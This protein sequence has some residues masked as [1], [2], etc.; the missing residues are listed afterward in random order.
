MRKS[1]AALLVLLL[2]LSGSIMALG[3]D[4]TN[5]VT[6]NNDSIVN[7]G[8]SNTNTVTVHVDPDTAKASEWTVDKNIFGKFFE[9]NGKD[10]YPGIYAQ[11]LANGS[12]EEWYTKPRPNGT[13]P[14]WW[15]RSEILY[16]DTNT[17]SGIAYPWEPVK[18]STGSESEGA[19]NYENT[20]GGNNG[21]RDE[22]KIQRIEVTGEA[23]QGGMKQRI[24][25]PDERT[26]AYNV[27]FSVR[28]EGSLSGLDVRLEDPKGNVLAQQ[29][30]DITSEWQRHEL[31]L[32]LNEQSEQRFHGSPFGEYELVFLLEGEGHV[33][34]D[35]VMLMS[36]DAVMG[37]YNPTTIELLREH[38]VTSLR[39]GGNYASEYR[40]MDGIGP[41]Q[42]R[43]VDENLNWGGLEPNYMGTNEFLEF[44]RLANIEPLIN[45]GFSEDITP[46]EAAQW[47][48]YVNGDITTPM[49][50]LRAEHGYPK[51]WNVKLW[52][53]GNEVY[54]GYQTGHTDAV[55]YAKRYTKYY[56]AMKAVDP[57][58][59]IHSS[60]IDPL[61][62]DFGDPFGTPPQW[63]NTL[64]EIA[65]DKV[66]AIDIHRYTRGVVVPKNRN[67][68]LEQ[69]DTDPVG[70]NQ[71]LVAFPT[72][73]EQLIKE[74][75]EE[76]TERGVDNLLINVGEWNLQ[77]VVTKGWPRAEYANM[78]H[79]SFVASKYNAFIRQ[80]DAV[81]FSY[82]RDNTLY[83]RPY[84]PFD[85]RPVNPANYTL[86]FYA[87]PFVQGNQSWHHLPLSVDSPTFTIPE[88]G[89]RIREMDDVP[90]VDAAGVISEQG[91]KVIVYVTNR[92]L[93]E[94]YNTE[95][96]IE[97]LLPEEALGKAKA[98]KVSVTLQSSGDPFTP[99]T[100]WEEING[101]ELQEF[102]LSPDEEGK[103]QLNLPAASVAK[104]EFTINK[105]Q[106]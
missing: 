79:A 68:W 3:M 82:Q 6:N 98:P 46:E 54:G 50:K 74:M 25:I 62:T 20:I 86:K 106:K 69:N 85:M 26:L 81:R 38:N 14:V 23:Y 57:S 63:N 55:D 96:V 24:A 27:E 91:N 97:G 16:R 12:F 19:V 71:V 101:F 59:T 47:V 73:Y 11:H 92:D 105:K 87:D 93:K 89:I 42:E 33:D 4:E 7:N 37:K 60:G 18:R 70:Y 21:K 100:S 80:G 103:V 72:Q 40:W 95:F 30:V 83:Y 31:R 2:I 77:P 9:M 17:Y 1:I 90:Y 66:E 35:W 41:L 22:R 15:Q 48:E 67:N 49:G 39:W 45:I 43:P 64:F 34:L 84:L 44:S 53:V 8:D 104:L 32:E 51:P 58:I 99:Q 13:E 75:R 29:S 52:Q 28:G 56:D 65:G 78:A 94:S 102:T 88:T 61:Y 10:T 76:A 5:S 36:G